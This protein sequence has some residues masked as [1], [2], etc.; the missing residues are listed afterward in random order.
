VLVH[1]AVL[2]E[3]AQRDTLCAGG[4]DLLTKPFRVDDLCACL[5]RLPGIRFEKPTA[6]AAALETPLPNLDLVVLPEELCARMTVAAEL[7]STTVLKACLEE[8]RQLGGPAEALADH[9]RQLLRAYDLGAIALLLSR[10]RVQHAES[11]TT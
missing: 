9:L 2:L 5:R 8:L 11:P 7:H 6:A 4:A 1:T 10:L 3:R